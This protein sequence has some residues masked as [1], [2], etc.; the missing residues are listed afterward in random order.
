MSAPERASMTP[1]G[2][3]AAAE[4][5]RAIAGVVRETEAELRR[6]GLHR[7]AD[8]YR[9]RCARLKQRANRMDARAGRMETSEK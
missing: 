8:E 9:R 3:R 1:A 5:N 7:R 2:W 4:H 6:L